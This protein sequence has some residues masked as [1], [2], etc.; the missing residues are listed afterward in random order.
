MLEHRIL[1]V[2]LSIIIR[3]TPFYTATPHFLPADRNNVGACLV[4][5]STG[6]VSAR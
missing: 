2:P 3:E 5:F 4:F 1:R 6:G